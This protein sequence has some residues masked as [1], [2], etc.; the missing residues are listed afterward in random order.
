M[1]YERAFHLKG[2]GES[3]N[4][5]SVGANYLPNDSFRSSFRYELR[6][7][8]GFGQVLSFG[9]AGEI[10]PG[11][12]ALGRFQYGNISFNGQKNKVTDGQVAFALRPHDTD[13]YGLLFGYTHRSSFFTTNKANEN[14][15]QIKADVLSVDGFYQPT[16]KLELYGRFALKFS[17]DGNTALPYADNMTMLMQTRAQYRISR[18]FDIAAENRF[19]YQPSSGSQKN[20]FGT[21]LGFWAT[22]D[23]RFGGGYNFSRLQEPLGFNSN[24]IYNKNGFYFVISSKISRLFDL[25]GTKKDGLQDSAEKNVSRD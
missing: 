22:P 1:G 16:N 6:N 20:W 4:N 24:S 7:R 2:E 23:L 14:P 21:E 9:S 13:K 18:L 3:Y 12:T 11:W 25:F 10:T 5:F 17:G 15:T 19:L 8:E